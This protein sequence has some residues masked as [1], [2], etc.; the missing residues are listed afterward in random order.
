MI[1]PR[2]GADYR[3]GFSRCSDCDVDLVAVP[4]S[5]NASTEPLALVSTDARLVVLASFPSEFEA[6][7]ALAALQSAGLAAML[8]ADNE[9]ALNAGL[10][11]TRGVQLLVLEEDT[12]AA[13]QALATEA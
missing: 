6:Q 5:T 9:G 2:C 7:V 12:A 1:C 4:D 3:E 8:R 11:F 10:T 13:R